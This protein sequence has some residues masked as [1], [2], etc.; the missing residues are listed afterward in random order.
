MQIDII[1]DNV[2][3]EIYNSFCRNVFGMNIHY[4][5][6]QKINFINNVI[7]KKI[8]LK[9]IIEEVDKQYKKYLRINKL[10]RIIKE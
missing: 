4:E 5:N 3:I 10:E 2:K 9:I 6:Y 7:K 8:T 1:P